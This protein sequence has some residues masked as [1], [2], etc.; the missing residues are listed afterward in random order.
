MGAAARFAVVLALGTAVAA[1]AWLA[2]RT[3]DADPRHETGSRDDTPEEPPEPPD[4]HAP[5]GESPLFGSAPEAEAG[6]V[7]S[8]L[9]HDPVLRTSEGGPATNPKNVEFAAAPDGEA[10]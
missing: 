2:V 9:R 5:A 1:A 8:A 10:L 6:G 7:E 4:D 3:F